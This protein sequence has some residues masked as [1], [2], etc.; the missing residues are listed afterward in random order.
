M[1]AVSFATGVAGSRARALLPAAVSRARAGRSRANRARH[2]APAGLVGSTY[3]LHG[4][5]GIGILAGAQ[6]ALPPQSQRQLRDTAAQV[7]LAQLAHFSLTGLLFR[8]GRQNQIRLAPLQLLA[9]Y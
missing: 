2:T 7:C 5:A 8:T 9:L 3:W 4:L 6:V 1:S